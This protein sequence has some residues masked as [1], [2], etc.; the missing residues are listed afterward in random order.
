MM[1]QILKHKNYF[2]VFLFALALL[3]CSKKY[4]DG[5]KFTLRTPLQ[6]IV[7][8]WYMEKYLVD[9]VES[10]SEFTGYASKQIGFQQKTSTKP[11]GYTI[12]IG[13]TGDTV[14]Y[15]YAT[16]TWGFLNNETTLHMEKKRV[17]NVIGI[18]GPLTQKQT[19]NYDIL[20]LT[21]N[22]LWIRTDYDSA[23]YE[24]HFKK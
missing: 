2:F 3:S 13:N 11:T 14:N 5:P 9:G 15:F 16:G 20:R 24:M 19:I 18:S 7:G 1:N 8:N 22:E 17:S 21:H 6:R 12:K 23:T 4:P 10:I